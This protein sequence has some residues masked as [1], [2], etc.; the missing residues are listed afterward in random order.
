MC[1]CP[2]ARC[3][4]HEEPAVTEGPLGLRW[5][6]FG[7]RGLWALGRRAGQDALPGARCDRALPPALAGTEDRSA[8]RWE[9]QLG[10]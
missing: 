8:Q 1:P 3:P 9:G 2:S 10:G 7:G 5:D 4:L 6:G